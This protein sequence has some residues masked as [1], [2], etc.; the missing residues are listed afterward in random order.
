MDF[1]PFF[2]F[3]EQKDTPHGSAAAWHTLN[4][5]ISF[6]MNFKLG[7]DVFNILFD[8]KVRSIYSHS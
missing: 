8:D 4:A 6:F 2:N 3:G 7:I 5:E 1:G